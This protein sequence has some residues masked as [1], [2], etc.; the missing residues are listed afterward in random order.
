MPGQHPYHPQQLQDGHLMNPHVQQQQQ[1]HEHSNFVIPYHANSSSN[2]QGPEAA[3]TAS[4]S[5]WHNR[6]PKVEPDLNL[7]SDNA[8]ETNMVQHN[9][10]SYDND[11]QNQNDISAPGKANENNTP[12]ILDND[13]A[14]STGESVS[15]FPMPEYWCSIN[16]F[17]LDVQ[18]GE[19]FKVKSGTRSVKVDGYVRVDDDRRFCLGALTNLQRK[20]ESDKTMR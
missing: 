15:K 1:H 19:T 6:T 10:K 2:E 13:R 12:D 4:S 8:N 20:P 5:G 11:N 7:P 9:R 3:T 14:T 18:V 17:E 16:Y